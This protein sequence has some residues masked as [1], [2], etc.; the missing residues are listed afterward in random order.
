MGCILEDGTMA[1]TEHASMISSS[2]RPDLGALASRALEGG[3]L[4]AGDDGEWLSGALCLGE[5]I[6]RRD[7]V[8][9]HVVGVVRAVGAPFW[10]FIGIDAEALET[11]RRVTYLE[12]LRQRVYQAVGQSALFS[13]DVITGSP[14]PALA[15][16]VGERGSAC[17]LIGLA[18][19]GT[20]ERLVSEDTVLQLTRIVEVPVIAVPPTCVALPMRALVAMD[21]SASSRRAA[22]SAMQLLGPGATL[23]LAHVEPEADLRAIGHEGL[24]E[25][26][27]RGVAAFNEELT[28]ELG[29]AGDVTIDTVLLR[30]EPAPALLDFAASHK[31]DLVAAG[32]QGTPAL[33]RHFV[34]SVSTALLRGARCIV[35]IAPPTGSLS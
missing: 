14:A 31:C 33:E 19:E 17:V 32:T 8:N 30:G 6:A 29:S 13:V 9:A 1:R 25:I 24:A 26:Y 20:A 4:I 34:G 18:D 23:S 10:K 2:T 27:E 5:L 3:V 28:T 22:R 16:T 11:G 21:Y 7:R 35:L 15:V 12:R